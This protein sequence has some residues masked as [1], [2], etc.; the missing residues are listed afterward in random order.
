M[1][2]YTDGVMEAGNQEEQFFTT[3]RLLALLNRLLRSA[4]ELVNRIEKRVALT[5]AKPSSMMILLYLQS[6][7]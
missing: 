1:L 6:G 2:G 5:R 7:E 4:A 3:E